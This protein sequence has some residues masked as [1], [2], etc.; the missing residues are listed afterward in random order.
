VPVAG[1]RFTILT[2][3]SRSGTFSSV[4]GTNPTPDTE[5]HVLYPGNDVL[6]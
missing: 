3:G 6:T 2:A 4:T 1:D 5:F